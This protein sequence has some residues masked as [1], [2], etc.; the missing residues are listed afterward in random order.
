MRLGKLKEL[1]N[2]LPP[3]ADNLHV[4][5]QG[6]DCVNAVI[7]VEIENYRNPVIELKISTELQLADMEG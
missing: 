6:C 7:G 5:A 2:K 4:F 1:L 3:E